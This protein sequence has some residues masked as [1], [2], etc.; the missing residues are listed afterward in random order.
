ME[1]ES[2]TLQ[3]GRIKAGIGRTSKRQEVLMLSVLHREQIKGA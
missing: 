3:V 2:G 1:S